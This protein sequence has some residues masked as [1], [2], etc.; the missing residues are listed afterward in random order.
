MGILAAL[1]EV[2]RTG[3]GVVV[4]AAMVDG[5]ANLTSLVQGMRAQG[6]WPNPP[7]GNV[8]DGGCPFYDTYTCADGRYV[9]VGALEPAFY[10]ELLAGLGLADADLPP[11]WDPQGWPVLRSTFT[12]IFSGRSRDEWAQ[13]FAG[14]DACVTPVLDMAEAPGHPQLAARGT[15]VT[16][17]VTGGRVPGPAPRFGP[18]LGEVG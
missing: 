12:D 18:R 1:L 13:A 8:L 14:T 2:G 4:D 3:R 17:P 9:A 10:A 5:A 6:L 16:D 7:G 15:F 11:Q